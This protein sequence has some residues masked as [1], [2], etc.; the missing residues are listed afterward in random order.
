MKS[1]IKFS[2]ILAS[3]FIAGILATHFGEKFMSKNRTVITEEPLLIVSQ[4]DQKTYSILPTGSILTHEQSSAEGYQTYKLYIN[5]DSDFK[6]QEYTGKTPAA[7]WARTIDKTE[8]MKFMQDYPLSLDE[9]RRVIKAQKL[10][11]E[12]Y[13]QI[14]R[15]WEEPKGEKDISIYDKQ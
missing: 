3:A 11:R 5:I 8:I 2:A 12:D 6:S 14:L 7:I 13:I 15:D 9:L 4:K 1:K 10:S